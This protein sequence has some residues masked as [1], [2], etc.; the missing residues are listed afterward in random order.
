MP[1]SLESIAIKVEES[2]ESRMNALI[3]ELDRTDSPQVLIFV[4]SIE[5]A[6]KVAQRL[7]EAD[8]PA[9]SFHGKRGDKQDQL[10]AFGNMEVTAL[11][12]TDLGA[13]GIDLP[14]VFLIVEFEVPDDYVMHLHRAGRTGR[15]GQTD[16]QA[17]AVLLY[18]ESDSGPEFDQMLKAKTR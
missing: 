18:S 10:A 9:T 7:Q 3:S 6:D 13:R 14:N 16:V 2:F 15:T 4:N 17:R 11:V 12:S 1:E 5:Q 8:V